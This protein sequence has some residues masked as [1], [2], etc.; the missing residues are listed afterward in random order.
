MIEDKDYLDFKDK[1]DEMVNIFNI[2]SI[3][4]VACVARESIDK[5]EA[6]EKAIL[7]KG[8]LLSKGYGK[9][10]EEYDDTLKIT[11]IEIHEYND[12]KKNIK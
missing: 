4:E 11:S 6:C 12:E 10:A 5:I 9:K 7:D 1:Y 8:I 3:V 2:A